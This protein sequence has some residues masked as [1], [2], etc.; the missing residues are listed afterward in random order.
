MTKNSYKLNLFNYFSDILFQSNIIN[1]PIFIARCN[2]YR[3]QS[4]VL[5]VSWILF[6]KNLHS[7][8]YQ[9]GVEMEMVG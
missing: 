5:F 9:H 3:N 8:R 2:S 6:T 4:E 1:E 7:S